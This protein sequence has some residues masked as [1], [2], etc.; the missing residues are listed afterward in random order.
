MR[1]GYIGAVLLVSMQLLA[2]A[3][4]TPCPADR[5]VDDIIAEVKAY[6]SKKKQRN[7]NPLPDT[8]CI[9]G[10][11][12]DTGATSPP[13]PKPAPRAESR[14]AGAEDSSS[15]KPPVD[16]CNEALGRALEAAHNVEVGDYYFE[17]QNYSA[18]LSRY[19]DA[20]ALKPNDAAIHVRLGRVLEKTGDLLQ[21]RREY[22]TA[23]K[24]AAPEKWS[25]EARN[26][27]A[28]LQQQP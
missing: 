13:A 3:P 20:V 25:E 11:C 28:R 17:K 5:P 18:A 6:Q 19:K 8:I 27:L 12:R 7:K 16:E 9:W 21:A 10:W 14:P 15:S 22:E 24:I 2:Q 4:P 26:A 1:V 23:E